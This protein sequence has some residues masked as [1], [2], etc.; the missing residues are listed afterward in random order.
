M[1]RQV[2]SDPRLAR[3]RRDTALARDELRMP[4]EARQTSQGVTSFAIKV[5]D[6]KTREMID[7]F[8]ARRGRQQ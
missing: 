2:K 6:P 3:L 4:T 7:N 1:P 5:G 8:L